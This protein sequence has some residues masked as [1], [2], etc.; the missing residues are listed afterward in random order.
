MHLF[1]QKLN[2][3]GQMFTLKRI[4]D[5]ADN[6]CNTH[7]YNSE[8]E[9]CRQNLIYVNL[10]PNY[11]CFDKLMLKSSMYVWKVFKLSFI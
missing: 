4:A 8:S 11:R 5:T 3:F 6:K 9:K 2:N 10:K 7:I 1:R